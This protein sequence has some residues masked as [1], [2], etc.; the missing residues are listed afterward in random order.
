MKK[1]L[2]AERLREVLHYDPGTGVF[3]WLVR[4]NNRV[5]IGDVAGCLHKGG[6]R[7]VKIDGESHLTH[8]LAWL[9]VHGRWPTHQIDHINGATGDNRLVN[10][11]EAT[12]AENCQ[13]KPAQ[14]AGNTSGYPGV[15]W[16]KDR[17]KWMV[18]IHANHKRHYL[19]LFADLEAA[20]AAYVEAKKRLHAF[21][22]EVRA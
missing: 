2:M 3:T 16:S 9:Y 17:Q 15:C 4:L 10:L 22:P 6:Y 11:R 14:Q 18:Q 13:N 12:H 1:A 7:R 8:R 21:Q 20:A 19:G 5:A